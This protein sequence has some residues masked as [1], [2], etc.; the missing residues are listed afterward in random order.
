MHLICSHIFIVAV[1]AGEISRNSRET[2][3]MSQG[4]P[5]GPGYLPSQFS[6]VLVGASKPCVFL[7][8]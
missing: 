6:E 2:K 1:S 4:D 5:T 8:F 3:V 7:P